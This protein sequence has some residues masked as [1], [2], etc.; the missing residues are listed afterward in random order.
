M[1]GVTRVDCWINELVACDVAITDYPFIT[2][3]LDISQL[4]QWCRTWKIGLICTTTEIHLLFVCE[5]C[6]Y[7]L[8]RNTKYLSID[9]NISFNRQLFAGAIKLQGCISWL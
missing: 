8:P 4:Q 3:Y 6:T 2:E 9:G 1:Y 7:A 5:R